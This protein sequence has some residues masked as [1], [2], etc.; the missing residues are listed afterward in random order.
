MTSF[1][2][3]PLQFIF[4][5][6]LHQY[7]S[8]SSTT[9]FPTL[10]QFNPTDLEFSARTSVKKTLKIKGWY[11]VLK[12]ELEL[13]KYR[14]LKVF[15]EDNQYLVTFWWIL[16]T[17]I[18]SV[19]H[20]S[21]QLLKNIAFRVN[22][23][24]GKSSIEKRLNGWLLLRNKKGFSCV[25]ILDSL[26]SGSHLPLWHP[27]LSVFQNVFST[28]SEI[29]SSSS[30]HIEYERYYRLC[31]LL[32]SFIFFMNYFYGLILTIWSLINVSIAFTV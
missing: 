18:L 11:V 20:V 7:C 1:D 5:F 16:C 32:L 23:Q 10:Q 12:K 30:A 25:Y 2:F 19:D 9:P 3:Y 29:K 15:S 28:T 26:Y 24:F 17:L 6:L 13:E 27:F 22:G 21:C 31:C 8:F 4:L 14:Y